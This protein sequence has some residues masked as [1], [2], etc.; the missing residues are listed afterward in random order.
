MSQLYEM[1]NETD[2][3]KGWVYA[4]RIYAK[5]EEVIVNCNEC[6]A[7]GR[8]PKKE[9]DVDIEGGTKY[10]DILLCGEYPLLIVSEKVIKDWEQAGFTGFKYYSVGINNVSSKKLKL[11][12]P[13]KYYHI[14]IQGRCELDLEMMEVEIHKK[15]SSCGRVIFNKPTW[16]IDKFYIK[17]SSWDGSD[18]FVSDLFPAKTLVTENVIM[19]ACKNRHTNFR[20]V[21]LKDSMNLFNEAIDYLNF[22]R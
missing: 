21:K 14:V 1:S 22:C 11:I 8:H 5:S 9:F 13:P 19:S 12:I 18:L 20:F 16:E 3:S 17:E 6:G 2:D 4:T 10:S 7:I 15:C